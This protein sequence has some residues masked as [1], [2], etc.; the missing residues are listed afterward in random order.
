MVKVQLWLGFGFG[1][2]MIAAIVRAG[3]TVTEALGLGLDL[4]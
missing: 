2:V 4:G 1:K 3:A